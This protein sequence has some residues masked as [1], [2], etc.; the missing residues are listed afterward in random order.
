MRVQTLELGL[1]VHR[2]HG[3]GRGELKVLKMGFFLLVFNFIL[4]APFIIAF[5]IAARSGAAGTAQRPFSGV[6]PIPE[7]GELKVVS[8]QPEKIKRLVPEI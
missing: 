4:V 8:P 3:Y 6:G 2:H 7:P 5:I 1:A